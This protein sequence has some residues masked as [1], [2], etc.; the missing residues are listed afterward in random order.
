MREGWHN[1]RKHTFHCSYELKWIEVKCPTFATH[2]TALRGRSA[3]ACALV[4]VIFLLCPPSHLLSP[5]PALLVRLFASNALQGV[6]KWRPCILL[7]CVLKSKGVVFALNNKQTNKNSNNNNN[8][9]RGLFRSI[10]KF[11]CAVSSATLRRR[12]SLLLIIWFTY[13]FAKLE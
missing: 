8:A 9:A 4:Y 5:N 13:Q 1:N 7:E 2:P 6:Q 11:K 12:F 10:E 3:C